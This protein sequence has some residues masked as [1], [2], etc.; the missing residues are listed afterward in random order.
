TALPGVA[1]AS[2]NWVYT[3]DPR[4]LTPNDPSYAAQ[5]HHTL[6]EVDD[7][8]DAFTSSAPG[9]GVLIGIA[10]NGVLISHPDLAPNVWT[11]PYDPPGGGDNDGNGYVDD[12]NGWDFVSNDN[13]PNHVGTD[14]HGTH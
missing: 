7:A 4:E 3:Y 5:Y 11:N 1:W 14:D 10:D 8:W 6:M 9:A 13:N 12:L 2:P